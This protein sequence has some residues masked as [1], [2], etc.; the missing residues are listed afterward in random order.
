MRDYGD[1]SPTVRVR[2]QG[3][4]NVLK[5]GGISGTTVWLIDVVPFGGNV[6]EGRRGT[7]RFHQTYNGEAIVEDK[8]WDVGD[9]RGRSIAERSGNT[10]GDDLYR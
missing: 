8:R 3:G 1:T 2:H 6:E 9:A 7:H 5:G 4:I 10:V